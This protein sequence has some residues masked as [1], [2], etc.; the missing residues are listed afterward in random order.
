[1]RRQ[2]HDAAVQFRAPAWIVAQAEQR[3]VA[4]G[5]SLSELLRHALRRELKDAA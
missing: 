2:T 5:M 1:M 3:A 4:Q